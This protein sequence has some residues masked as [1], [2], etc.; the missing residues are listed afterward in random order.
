M[1]GNMTHM[2]RSENY[3]VNFKLIENKSSMM[4]TMWMFCQ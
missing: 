1:I 4:T 2:Q 3:R